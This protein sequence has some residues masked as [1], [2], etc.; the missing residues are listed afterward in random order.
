MRLPAAQ[1]THIQDL[2][3]QYQALVGSVETSGKRIDRAQQARDEAIK[4]EDAIID[5]GD[6]GSLKQALDRARSRGNIEE[7]H[8]KVLADL[9]QATK[10]AQVNLQ[11]IGLWSGTLE[12]LEPLPIPVGE[13]VDRFEA[14]MQELA[15]SLVTLMDKI[16]DHQASL[17]EADR[18]LDELRLRGE[19]PSENEL[20]SAR[21]RRDYGW[22]LVRLEWLEKQELTE[23]KRAYDPDQDL[24][25]AYE[26]SV[27]SAD[28]VGDRLRREAGRV[29]NQAA[30]MAEQTKLQMNLKNLEEH[31]V[32]LAE[33]LTKVQEEWQELW[34]PTGLDPLPPKEM[35]AWIT[36]QKEL[37]HSAENLRALNLE[38]DR[39]QGQISEH[40]EEL[41]KA[42]AHLAEPEPAPEE[43][44]EKLLNRC[45]ALVEAIQESARGKK[46]LR[47][48]VGDLNAEIQVARGEKSDAIRK[49]KEWQVQWSDAIKPLGLT[50]E[51]SPAAVHVV[52]AK[53]DELFKKLD[54]ARSLKTRI[55]GITRDAAKFGDDV[56]ALVN[57]LAL[58]LAKMPPAQA[59]AELQAR[60]SRAQSDEAT[61]AAL[62]KQIKEKG[63]II[64]E[65]Q[66][67][68]RL[69]EHSLTDL[70]RQ[71]GCA[72]FDELE[73]MELRSKEYQEL[74]KAMGDLEEQILELAPGA[75][76]AEIR[77]EAETV[78]SDELPERIKE[79]A[80]QIQELEEER[81]ALAGK[82]ARAENELGRMDGNSRAAEAA[83]HLQGMASKIRDG[84]EQY[85]RLRMA[86]VILRR[87]IERY[88]VENQGPLLSRGEELFN[89]LTLGSFS[90]LTTDFNEKD[91]LILLGVRPSGKRVRVEGMSKGTRDQLYLSL[92][93]ASLEKY[94]EASEPMPFVVDDILINFDNRRAEATLGALTRLSEKTQVLFF[95]HHGHLVELA[96][97]VAGEG[98]V[99][100]LHLAPE[101]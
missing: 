61:A 63:K 86:S 52:M 43:T 5:R 20:V 31:K 15:S 89:C 72:H 55:E 42:L 87:E 35:R 8:R 33:A 32:R 2:G 85:L 6:P 67:T 1:R 94:L 60:L 71:A 21:E 4:K 96:Q 97:R 93:L 70:C 13:T 79:I 74:Q 92:R 53:L 22:K 14:K 10:Q 90:R 46:E 49:L 101:S 100:V 39:L 83:E 54:E 65:A 59:A 98:Q 23:E 78:N 45:Q 19:V 56:L 99:R 77:Q 50:G 41:G 62:R 91:E 36:R 30:L 88:R 16:S 81:M 12:E 11:K 64:Q 27:I 40:I 28:Q 51:I 37:V 48:K 68:I 82:I 34:S 44:L 95:T 29:A 26:K 24:P 17:S 18:Q 73:A 58:D 75:T 84:V 9:I 57:R 66:E 69:M 25:E 7:T 3:G 38:A 76:L 47:K 80:R